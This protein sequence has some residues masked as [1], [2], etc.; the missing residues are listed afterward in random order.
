M[1]PV[2]DYYKTARENEDI[3]R[4]VLKDLKE[5]RT[6]RPMGSLV[7]EDLDVESKLDDLFEK[8]SEGNRRGIFTILNFTKPDKQSATIMFEDVAV[9]SG[10]GAELEYKIKK[11]NSVE[12]RKRIASWVS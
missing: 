9:L 4:N 11:D 8:Y 1:F 12:Y 10:G 5:N 6:E 2:K 3:F 7:P